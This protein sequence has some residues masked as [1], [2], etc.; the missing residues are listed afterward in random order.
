[1]FVCM[2]NFF[3][4]TNMGTWF[5]KLADHQPKQ[6]LNNIS[7]KVHH[8]NYSEYWNGAGVGERSRDQWEGKQDKAP[9]LFWGKTQMLMSLR[10][11]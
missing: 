3:F 7:I 2:L 5:K 9:I 11:W 8:E 4:F 1:M 10:H 6:Q